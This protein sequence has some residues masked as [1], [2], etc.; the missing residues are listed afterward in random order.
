MALSL[1][2]QK[3]LALVNDVIK[4]LFGLMIFIACFLILLEIKSQMEIDL[5][6]SYDFPVDE[7][8]REKF[9]SNFSI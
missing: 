5:F 4:L 6:P 3:G 9:W 1:R 7:W 8:M 2:Q